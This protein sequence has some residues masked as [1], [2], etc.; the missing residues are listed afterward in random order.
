[1]VYAFLSIYSDECRKFMSHAFI[2]AASRTPVG[3]YLGGLASLK[4][5]ELGA[6]AIRETIARSA[7][8]PALVDQVIMGQVVSAGCG[9]AP[10]RQASMLGG[11]SP[12]IGAAT[13][14][15]VCGSGL[16]SVMLADMAIRCG[17]YRC[18]VAGGMESMSAA[19]HL[20]RGGRSGWKYGNQS[21]LDAVDLD[22]LRCSHGDAAMGCY[23]ESTAMKETI[24][25]ADQDH[26]AVQSHRR[27]IA[28]QDSGH[29]D[30]ESIAMTV[31]VGKQT[32]T[33]TRDESPRR[34]STPESL[35]KLSAAFAKDGTVTA[36]NASPLS[37][38][39]AAVLV[40]DDSLST[41][42]TAEWKF[43]IVGH[44]NFAGE[45]SQLFVAPV[46]AVNRLLAK[47][48]MQVQDVDLFELNEAFASQTIACQRQL[49]IDSD[50]LNIHGGAIAIGHPLGCSG[51]RVLVTL[52]HNLLA[53]NKSIGVAA[54]CLGGGEAVAMMIERVS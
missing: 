22:G 35:A 53:T 36:G 13:V 20:L 30:K 33:V 12:S 9:Q 4:A 14:N 40:V 47:T 38:G 16:Y 27:A 25:R 8:E 10:A 54:L 5:V 29:F 24:S 51:T 37:D 49:G 45:P 6:A 44:S 23:A 34:D 52:I 2:V 50:R 18:V 17:E 1:L 28:A 46:G 26:W 48:K 32:Q 7:V 19:P 43:R 31:Q 41:S 11:L 21:L 39:G 3:K 42:S 15:K